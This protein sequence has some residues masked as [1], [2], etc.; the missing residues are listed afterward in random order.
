MPIVFQDRAAI[1]LYDAQ[2]SD[3]RGER[4][5]IPARVIDDVVVRLRQFKTT[6]EDFGVPFGNIHVL[7]T[8][9]TRVAQN[10]AEFAS[11]IKEE[12]GWN[13]LMLSKEGEGRIGALGVASSSSSVEGLVMDLGG[14]SIQ[15]TWATTRDG[16]ITTSPK[17]SVSYPYGT[18]ALMRRLEEIQK[19]GPEAETELK[20]EMIANFQHAYRFLEVPESL[21]KAAEA[22]GGFCLYLCGGGFRGWGTF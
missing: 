1:S 21:R 12:T 13:I 18:A 11:R 9:A 7:A 15:I 5:S 4:G 2:A 6:C 22:R 10:A 14:G 3:R 20:E 8:E 17:G 16:I 19:K